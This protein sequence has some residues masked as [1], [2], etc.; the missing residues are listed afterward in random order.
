MRPKRAQ[1]LAHDGVV[2]FE[3]QP[4]QLL[5]QPHGGQVRIAFQ[6][7][8][9]LIHERVQQARPADAFLVGGPRTAILMIRQ[10]AAYAFAVDSQQACNPALRGAPI[11]QPDDLVACGLLHRCF[12]S[13]TTSWLRVATDPA[14][15]AS[16]WKRGARIVRSSAVSPVR[17]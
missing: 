17:P 12:S 2:A 15:R 1:P 13:L 6:Q 11:V 7:L 5:M 9:D 10:H 3:T 8:R 16:L 4:A 14:S